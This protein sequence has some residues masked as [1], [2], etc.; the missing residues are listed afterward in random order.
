MIP[1]LLAVVLLTPA[2]PPERYNP[3]ADEPVTAKAVAKVV[4][5]VKVAAAG[6]H[7]HRCP[8]GHEWSHH[9]SSFGK[10]ADHTCPVCGRQDWTPRE[11]NTRIVPGEV[12]PAARPAP[13]PAR[14]KYNPLAAAEPVIPVFEFRPVMLP[15]WCPPGRT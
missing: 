4:G 12:R 13:P 3:L 8:A 15:T 7:V 9:E 5:T 1:S 10:V 6:W 14:S 2:A 11:R